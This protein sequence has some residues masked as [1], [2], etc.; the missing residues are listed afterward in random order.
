MDGYLD[1]QVPYTLANVRMGKSR[2]FVGVFFSFS[3]PS[4]LASA[5]VRLRRGGRKL[6]L[7]A[8][9][10]TDTE[11]RDVRC[12]SVMF[13]RGLVVRDTPR[14]RGAKRSL[15][16]KRRVWL[17][18]FPRGNVSVLRRAVAFPL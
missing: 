4:R 17:F 13:V 11:K 1:Q 8:P 2:G 5:R 14:Q 3:P 15:S 9:L 10:Q 18:V 6:V 16:S 7:S 12:S